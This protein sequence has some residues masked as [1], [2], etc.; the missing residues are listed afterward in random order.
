VLNIIGVGLKEN[1]NG[2]IYKREK[3]K[4]HGGRRTREII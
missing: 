2:Y 3:K 1:K 4:R